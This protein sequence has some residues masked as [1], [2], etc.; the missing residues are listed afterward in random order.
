MLFGLCRSRERPAPLGTETRP[1][2]GWLA[3]RA[4]RADAEQK[5]QRK[6][7][8]KGALIRAAQARL[9]CAAA[10]APYAG[11]VGGIL[12]RA[13]PRRELALP[14]LAHYCARTPDCRQ[15][16]A[17]GPSQAPASLEHRRP[18]PPAPGIVRPAA[19]RRP[20]RPSH[21]RQPDPSTRPADMQLAVQGAQA[22]GSSQGS[23]VA[24]CSKRCVG[25]AASRRGHGC[26]S[27]G[28]PPSCVMLARTGLHCR[29]HN[30]L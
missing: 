6:A 29:C 4:S 5:A 16:A 26:C 25:L 2:R 11:R 24:A 15:E 23:A 27:G 10:A 18:H 20:H 12:V 21:P 30:S 28:P 14:D 13:R 3:R 19:R 7:A 1:P 22:I 9:W 17:V 8:L